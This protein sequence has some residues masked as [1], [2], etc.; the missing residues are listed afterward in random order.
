MSDLMQ[1]PIHLTAQEI[2][3]SLQFKKG[4]FG[5]IAL[6]SGQIQRAQACLKYLENPIKNFTFLGYT[7][8]T[9]YYKG[10]KITVGNGGFYS[11]DSAFVTELLCTGGI[12]VLI[13]LGSCGALKE[14][15][16]IGDFIVIDKIIRG[17]GAT[18]YY[19]DD[20]FISKVDKDLTDKIYQVFIDRKEQENIFRGGVWTTDALLRETKEIVNFYIRKEAICVDMVS[21]PFVTIAD[22]Y[23]KKA[24]VVLAVSDNLIT[25][26]LGFVD[27]RFFSAQEKMIKNI[28]EIV[29]RL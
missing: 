3:E 7:F 27:F 15:I 18:R 4:D 1:R 5:E 23:N 29:E 16:N 28:F 2:L 9:G 20:S 14:K 11:P 13:R 21:S 17:E 22:L 6:V 24:A 10:K 25:G 12:N 19:V 26:E 8:W